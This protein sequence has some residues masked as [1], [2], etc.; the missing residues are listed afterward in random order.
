MKLGARYSTVIRPGDRSFGGMTVSPYLGDTDD[1]T[2]ALLAWDPVRQQPR[3]QVKLSTL[4]N[5]GALATSGGLVFQ[6]TGDGWFF[7]Y[8]A[9]TGERLWRFQARLGIV[10]PPITY[11]GRGRQYFSLLVGYGG[12]TRPPS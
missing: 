9:A 11:E 3:W 12:P 2:G 1:G 8:D 7:A 10:S 6:G 4:W 5:G